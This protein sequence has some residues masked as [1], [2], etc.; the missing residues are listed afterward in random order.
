MKKFVS[1][2]LTALLL[3]SLTACSAASQPGL[4][5]A[6]VV[7]ANGSDTVY[8][9]AI[10]Q[11]LDHSSLEQ[12][13]LAIHGK[14]SELVQ[15]QD[16]D[17][18]IREFNGQNDAS[19]LNQIG[20]QIVADGYDLILPIG[21]LAAQAMVT[22]AEDTEIPV[23]YA[24][25]SDPESAGLTGFSNV[26]GTS[27][28]L[29]TGLILDMMCLADPDISAVG[30]L[31]SNSETNSQLPIAQAKEWL[32]ERGIAW[33]E[34]TGNTADEILSA[35]ASLV[36]AVDAVFTPTDNVVMAVAGAV[37]EVLTEAG[38]PHYTGADSFVTAGAFATCGVNYTRLGEKTAEMA[39]EILRG[40][41]V[42]AFQTLDGGIVTVNTE[43]AAALGI[44]PSVFSALAQVSDVVEVVT[45]E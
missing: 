38:I 6:G 44:D 12:I 10:V 15:G 11:Q 25:I 37:A 36:G 17:I 18:D 9:V 30:L 3:V 27:D 31:Y 34:A 5:P 35:A 41:D 16:W 32:A 2:L 1:V 24:A 29:D 39:V 42:G 19:M 43:T 28:A 4:S 22:A 21:T 14:L 20:A 13:R 45:G 23:V 7:S 26:T 40:G 8:T 33:V